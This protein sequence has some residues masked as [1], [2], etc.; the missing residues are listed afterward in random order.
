[1]K[2]QAKL[3]KCTLNDYLGAIISMSLRDY[4][5]KF[6]ENNGVKYDAPSEVNMALI[7][8]NREVV[9]KV[10]DLRLRNDLVNIYLR[11]PIR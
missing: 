11:F 2:S 4:F 6:P 5:I 10:K 1:M 3:Y 8:S 7:Y 9:K